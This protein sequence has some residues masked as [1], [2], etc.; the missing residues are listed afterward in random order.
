MEANAATQRIV[1]NDA[2]TRAFSIATMVWSAVGLLV[3]VVMFLIMDINRPQ[4][5]TFQ[6]GAATL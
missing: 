6:M 2:V 5:G 1:Y 4:R 3:G